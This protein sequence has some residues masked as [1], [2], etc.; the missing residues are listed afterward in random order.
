[1]QPKQVLGKE[2]GMAQK[3]VYIVRET[4]YQSANAFQI[5]RKFEFSL[6]SMPLFPF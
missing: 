6:G 2:W 5:P 1:M 4:F 3:I